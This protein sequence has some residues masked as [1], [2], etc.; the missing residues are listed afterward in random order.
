MTAH[1]AQLNLNAHPAPSPGHWRDASLDEYRAHL[2]ALVP[3]VDACAKARDLKTC[4]P[5][6]VGPDDNIPFGQGRRL[7]RYGWLRVLLSRAEDPDQ[8]PSKKSIKSATPDHENDEPAGTRPP[9]VTTSALLEAAKARLAADLAQTEVAAAPE[10]AHTAERA[11]MRQILAGKDF[12]GVEQ[13]S[14]RDTLLEKLGNWLDNIFDPC[15]W[16]A[17]AFCVGGPRAG[18][19]IY[20]RRVHRAGVGADA[21]GAP[22]AGAAGSGRSYA[23]SRRG[24]GPRLAIVA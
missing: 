18:V 4:D 5:L 19:G 17:R 10:P 2:A 23:C 20:P 24:L 15:R 3:I 9:P 8:K 11:A 21:A 13:Q 14:V 12:R 22:L 6:L 16:A 1:A 7:I